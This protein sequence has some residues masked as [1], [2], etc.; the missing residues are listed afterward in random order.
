[1]NEIDLKR[2][3]AYFSKY[4]EI[5]EKIQPSFA[6]R[7][8]MLKNWNAL[9]INYEKIKIHNHLPQ[10]YMLGNKKALFYTMTQY[11][12]AVQEEKFQYIPLTFHVQDG[13]EDNEYLNFLKFFYEKAKL[14][15][16]SE[17]DGFKGRKVRNIWIVKPGEFTNRG[18]GIRVCLQLD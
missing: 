16:K 10:N 18:N 5:E 6:K 12:K 14:S 15:K 4:K 8:K 3:I 11:Y 2:W 7:N 17:A 1:M 9:A 13:L